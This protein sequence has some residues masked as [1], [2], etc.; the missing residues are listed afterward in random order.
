MTTRRPRPLSVTRLEDRVTPTVNIL[1][2]FRFETSG[3]FTNHPDRIAVIR[4]AAADIGAR[5]SDTLDAIPFPSA[6]GDF[7]KAKFERPSGL[8]G[9][10]TEIINLLVPAN[11]IVVFVGARDLT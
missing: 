11:S 3:F 7:W 2:D 9:Q 8:G 4:A 1:F 6:P 5:F 10:D